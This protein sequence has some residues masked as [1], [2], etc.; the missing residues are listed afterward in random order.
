MCQLRTIGSEEHL[1]E[2]FVAAQLRLC[3]GDWQAHVP[4]RCE[5][6]MNSPALLSLCVQKMCYQ[7]RKESVRISYSHVHTQ[8]VSLFLC[9]NVFLFL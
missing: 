7:E 1:E 4:G 3:T 8:E 6:H 2:P 5:M 9:P